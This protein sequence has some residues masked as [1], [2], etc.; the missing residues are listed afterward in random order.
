[1][2]WKLYDS[3]MLIIF[4]IILITSIIRYPGNHGN[5]NINL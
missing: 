4:F 5:I 3:Y 1:M 2:I